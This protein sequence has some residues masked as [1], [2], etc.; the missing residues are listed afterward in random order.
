[1][2]MKYWRKTTALLLAAFAAVA[3]VLAPDMMK[4]SAATLPEYRNPTPGEFP[5]MGWYSIPASE[6]S[7]ERYMEMREAGFNLSFTQ[8][9]TDSQIRGAL[10]ACAGTGVKL[11]VPADAGSPQAVRARVDEFKSNPRL[12]GW[13]LRDEPVASDFKSLSA[14][15]NEV[16]AADPSHLLYL[17]LLPVFVAPKTLGTT[18]YA[19]YLS[20]FTDEV[21]L[22]LISYDMYPV[23]TS[24]NGTPALSPD[25]FRNL[26]AVSTRCRKIG[27]PFWAF[28]L[29]TAHGSYPVPD[30]AQLRVEAFSALAYGAQGI[31]YFT[32]WQPAP[33]KLNFH[34]API[35]RSGKRTAVYGLVKQMNYE[36]KALT[37]VFLGCK[38]QKTGFA[39]PLPYSGAKSFGA[40]PAPMR[41]NISA[42]GTGFLVSQLTGGDGKKYLAVVNRDIHNSQTLNYDFRGNLTVMDH[43][44]KTRAASKS[45]TLTP[46]DCLLFILN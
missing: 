10:A 22:P 42:S 14:L 8:F 23:Q 16:I 34:D 7:R 17:N 3:V 41:G 29:S 46:G 28:C 40:L 13:F 19:R 11:M 2:A 4:T 27:R 21:R 33:S 45:E 43:N 5:V 12:G 1:M 25:L 38:V 31:Q 37:N 30:M 39:G 44:G 6:S 24:K 20:D 32:Y 15:R 36:I 9:A 35:D 26:E 18:D